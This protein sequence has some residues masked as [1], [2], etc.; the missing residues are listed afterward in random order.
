VKRHLAIIS[1]LA[2]AATLRAAEPIPEPPDATVTVQRELFGDAQNVKL[3]AGLLSDDDTLVREQ[4]LRDLGATHNV[5]AG[6]FLLKGLE[7][8]DLNVRC[9]AAAA[10]AEFPA[11]TSGPIILKA[12]QSPDREVVFVALRSTRL[13]EFKSAADAIR[14]LLS[15]DDG[16]IVAVAI[17]TLTDLGVAL[18]PS[19]LARQLQSK[20]L[21]VRLRAAENAL[22]LDN[23]GQALAELT[24]LAKEDEPAVRGRAVEALGKFAYNGSVA[25]IERAAKDDSPLVRRGAVLAFYRAKKGERI[26]PFLDDLS[27]LVVLEAS[28]A[29]G[30]LKCGDCTQRLFELLLAPLTRPQHLAARQSLR[31]IGGPAVIALADQTIRQ[32]YERFLKD[33]RAFLEAPQAQGPSEPRPKEK[34]APPL[35]PPVGQDLGHKVFYLER[36]LRSCLWLLGEL[37]SDVAL[38]Y[39]LAMVPMGPFDDSPW[40]VGSTTTL[41]VNSAVL[42]DVVESAGKIGDPRAVE[43]LMAFLKAMV[44]RGQD[45]LVSLSIIGR[46]PLP[47]NEQVTIATIQALVRLGAADKAM[48]DILAVVNTKYVGARLNRAT[49]AVMQLFPQIVND[50]N[51]ARVE[52][53]VLDVLQDAYYVGPARYMVIKAA[54][55]LKIEKTKDLLKTILTQERPGRFLM[56]GAAWSLQQMGQTLE[57]PDPVVDE[58]NWIITRDRQ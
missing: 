2:L 3:L 7:D 5:A 31:Q 49:A 15:R 40:A 16:N 44:K 36:N 4:A 58:G 30:D 43:P 18:S 33:T 47:Y 50:G 23:P 34:A 12:L 41:P 51:R 53:C 8:R 24:R 42:I 56:T 20:H 35:P 6:P 11:P 27:P 26:R 32:T 9:S 22:L 52:A 17:A 48:S 19:D 28:K 37:K 25:S 29:A 45:Y 54:G 38:E 39:Q 10:A 1:F 46:P 14:A 57:I 13:T 55:K 21:E